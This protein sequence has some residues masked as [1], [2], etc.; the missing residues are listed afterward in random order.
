MENRPYFVFGDLA[1]NILAGALVGG[2]MTLIF[3]SEWNML[4]AMLVGMALGMI[5]SLPVAFLGSAL[6]GAMEVMLPVMTTGMLSGMVVSMDATMGALRFGDGAWSGG[7][8]G[9][10]VV[11]VTYIANAIVR[12]RAGKWTQ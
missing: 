11:I 3:G 5:I 12:R 4:L 10:G 8:C 7:L 1:V 2:V 6:F 9:A